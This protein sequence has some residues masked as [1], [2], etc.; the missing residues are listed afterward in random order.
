MADKTP[1]TDP[2][3]VVSLCHADFDFPLGDKAS[4]SLYIA[5]RQ[6]RFWTKFIGFEKNKY[7]LTSLPQLPSEK[8]IVAG[9]EVTVRYMKGGI[10]C[11]FSSHVITTCLEP[12]PFL[13]LRYPECIELIKLRTK[14]RASCFFPVT[15]FW[16]SKEIQGRVVDISKS[17]YKVIALAENNEHVTKVPA[18]ADV[19]SQIIMDEPEN[20]LYA[21]SIVRRISKE[22]NK[23]VFGLEFV[24][25]QPETL[26]SIAEY[27]HKIS[28]Y[29]EK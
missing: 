25:L 15:I 16:Q 21:K 4:L 29:V 6:E 9:S 13:F 27:I 10:I 24:D 19:F 12:V 22:D 11:G 2:A 26:Q 28:S 14:N 17:G 3:Q 5:G 23:F 8:Q 1:K 18:G 7:V 20:A